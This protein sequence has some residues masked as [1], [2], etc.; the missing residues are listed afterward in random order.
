MLKG[1]GFLFYSVCETA[2]VRRGGEVKV[3]KGDM[4][5]YVLLQLFSF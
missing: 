1:K 3:Q 2:W 5:K 4:H